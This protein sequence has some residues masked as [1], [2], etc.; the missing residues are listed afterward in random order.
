LGPIGH[1]K[2]PAFAKSS[3]CRPRDTWATG[4][5]GGFTNVGTVGSAY[6][7]A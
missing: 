7:A 6:V 2:G 5:K 4:G 3:K 1:S